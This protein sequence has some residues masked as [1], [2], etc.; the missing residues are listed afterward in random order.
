MFYDFLTVEACSSVYRLMY[1]KVI[2]RKYCPTRYFVVNDAIA[3]ALTP[4]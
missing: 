1:Q 2:L 4:M 3:A